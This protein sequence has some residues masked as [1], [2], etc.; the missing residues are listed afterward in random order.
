MKY[1][2]F[3]AILLASVC[4]ENAATSGDGSGGGILASNS[5]NSSSASATAPTDPADLRCSV[6]GDEKVSFLLF[7]SDCCDDF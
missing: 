7:F 2:L 6:S 5:P 3:Y 4:S 1:A